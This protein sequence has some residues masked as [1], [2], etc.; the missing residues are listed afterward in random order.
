MIGTLI[1]V[2]TVTAGGILGALVRNRISSGLSGTVIQ[3][4]GLFTLYLGMSMSLSAKN[5]I[6]VLFSIL[7]GGLA[8]EALDIEG[9][10]DSLGRWFERRFGSGD[11]NFTR[12]FV[13]ASLL[14]CV[15]PMAIVGSIQDGL[16]GDYQILVTKAIMDGFCS[17]A[18]AST[19][20]IG[21]A[22]SALVILAY[23]GALTLFASWVRGFLTDPVIS[24]MT[25]T[26]GLMIIGIGINL[27]EIKKLRVGNLL[28]GLVVAVILAWIFASK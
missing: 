25:A 10:L 28:P 13:T 14:F 20:G 27:L 15:G 5:G 1:N 4:I 2:G 18:F 24:A 21:V 8:G 23:Q 19:L 3:G 7:I 26:G 12:G 16:M 17:V 22:F 6:I 11:G 9:R